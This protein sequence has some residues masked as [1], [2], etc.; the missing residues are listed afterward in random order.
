[1]SGQP[2]SVGPYKIIELVGEG[3]FGKTVAVKLITKHG[4]N[5]KDIRNLRQEIDILRKLQHE[6]IIQML[7]AFETKTDFCVVTELGQGELF[8]IL[9]D[10]QSLP[11]DVVRSI[12]RQLVRALHYLH[13]NR[14][15]H[16]DMKP[17]N[18]LVSAN[19]AV[20]LCDFGFARAMSSS[21][22]VVT[23][24]KGT[25]L[26]MAPELVQEQPYNHT[27]DLWSLGVIL[28]ELFVGQPPFYTNSIYTLIKQIV[29]DPVRYPATMSADFRSFL[30]GLLEKQPSRRLDWPALLEHPFVRED[31]EQQQ[32]QEADARRQQPQGAGSAVIP[33][34]PSGEA[35]RTAQKSTTP[36]TRGVTG[37]PAQAARAY[38]G[39]GAAQQQQQQQQQQQAPSGSG[40]P[41]WSTPQPARPGAQQQQPQ[42]HAATEQRVRRPGTGERRQDTPGVG[43]AAGASTAAG[44]QQQGGAREEAEGLAAD[45]FGAKAAA[46][47]Q[48]MNEAAAAGAAQQLAGLDLEITMGPAGGTSESA[49]GGAEGRAEG[50]RQGGAVV[51][52]HRTPSMP[53]VSP[54]SA[55]AMQQSSA[56][57]Q[58]QQ[59]TPPPQQ[60]P[61]GATHQQAQL[62]QDRGPQQQQ[63]EPTA[64][65]SAL[66]SQ[67]Q[68]ALQE[69]ERRVRRGR[70]GAAACW[71]DPQLVAA[72][73]ELLEPPAGL[74]A[75]NVARWVRQ[76]ELM[77][78]LQL[79]AAILPHPPSPHHL[80]TYCQMLDLIMHVAYASL[81]LKEETVTLCLATL[82]EADTTGREEE[83]VDL[84]CELISHRGSWPATTA[85]CTTLGR[86]VSMAV[87]HLCRAALRR[88]GS[89]GGSVGR[90]AEA[91]LRAV[92]GKRAA[93]K[94]CR[95]IQDA[96]M[97]AAP[98]GQSCVAAAVSAL[99]AL[100]CCPADSTDLCSP[101][102]SYFPCTALRSPQLLQQWQEPVM[103]ALVTAVRCD[104]TEALLNSN[105]TLATLCGLAGQQQPAAAAMPSLLLL[106]RSSLLRPHLGAAAVACRAQEALLSACISG[107]APAL[108]LLTLSSVVG[109]LVAHS[110]HAL[111]ARALSGAAGGAEGVLERLAALVQALQ[112]D[113]LAVSALCHALAAVAALVVAAPDG[114]HP[115]PP[116]LHGMA[117]LTDSHLLLTRRL[118]QYKPNSSMPSL[119]A[120]EGFPAATGLLD[121]PAALAAVLARQQPARLLHSGIAGA[122][123][124]LVASL[125]DARAP[126]GAAAEIS[127]AGLLSLLQALQ[128]V[129][130]LEAPAVQLFSQ[131]PQLAA[132]LLTLL[133]PRA[134]A[135]MG[136]FLKAVGGGT[137]GSSEQRQGPEER[138]GSAATAAAV[139]CAAAGAL[140][141]PFS[142]AHASPQ[143]EAFLAQLQQSLVA[144]PSIVGNLL[145]ALQIA[146]PGAAA[147]NGSTSSG[148][149]LEQ[150]QQQQLV[151]GGDAA[152]LLTHCVGLLARVVMAS[153]RA[154]ELF[155]GAGGME[156][157]L[158]DRLL[159]PTNP[160]P[161]VISALLI[162]SQLARST[163]AYY[164]ALAGCRLLAHMPALLTHDD[165]TVRARSCNLL[166]NLCRHSNRFYGELASSGVVDLLIQ[167]CRDPDHSVRKFACF[168]IGNAGFHN[169]SLY[170]A[171]RPSVPPLVDLLRDGEDRTRANAAGALGNLVRN[172]PLLCRDIVA[173]GALQAMLEVVERGSAPGA[174]ASP[175]SNSSVPIALFSLGNL[176]A[177]R[178]CAE[179]LVQ[180]GLRDVLGRTLPLCKADPTVH[181][182]VLRIQ[183][184]LQQH[185][186]AQR[187]R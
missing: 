40:R 129:L 68:Q 135:A 104:G 184:K 176:C 181:K 134:M 130:R 58:Q 91:V 111:A 25:P 3:S 142:H 1:M 131:Q 6:N 122:V 84:C 89:G 65:G 41:K 177:H 119:E 67:L 93:G 116:R 186:Q 55:A 172:S 115:P 23:S 154:L 110:G 2:T 143:I 85:G 4:K 70:D 156:P 81:S 7:D 151:G 150:Q 112:S 53:V 33:R 14:I 152:E 61:A 107:A 125:T 78:A 144:Q 121:G 128:W 77:Q 5:E 49:E 148:A 140:A 52:H 126:P 120:L 137:G 123:A 17:Q 31:R 163:D 141:A 8:Q 72:L 26:Y 94:L 171:L 63:D 45:L 60:Q 34:Q 165:A 47:S 46:P 136:A 170:E 173:A 24:I 147:A 32:Q 132:S 102:A 75:K 37:P 161:V 44:L 22:L 13:T 178:E 99:A 80:D 20:K 15:I 90:S 12:A 118:L 39:K 174:A 133:Q 166:G 74:G 100:V 105:A 168:A 51:R 149:G 11:E 36:N 113:V 9:E 97:G 64:N 71:A 108:A 62:Q 187:Q 92:L 145:D 79:L 106:H 48:A 117:S 159:N 139:A 162:I 167:L 59:S 69:A 155:V 43:G 21:T 160:T 158:V 88:G 146:L 127:P 98:G 35:P 87:H 179:A 83:V 54:F 18:I 124:Q 96:Q 73:R 10:D 169:A 50:N 101:A 175:D 57:Q 103:P 66:P 157:A 138:S 29:R 28:Y 183:Q 38:A 19:G 16:R 109:G 56:L 185:Q 164:D 82:A 27:V 153:D 86:H 114:P 95:C 182:Y 180:L 76:P 30:Q 42:Q